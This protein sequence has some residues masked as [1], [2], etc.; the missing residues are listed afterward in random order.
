MPLKGCGPALLK[1]K[2]SAR[3]PVGPTKGSIEG[4]RPSRRSS[5]RQQFCYHGYPGDHVSVG[6]FGSHQACPFETLHGSSARGTLTFQ[7]R[8]VQNTALS[9]TYAPSPH[10]LECAGRRA[11]PSHYGGLPGIE[12]G[13]TK[14]AGDTEP[15]ARGAEC[16]AREHKLRQCPNWNQIGRAHV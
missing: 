7:L 2:S 15:V 4:S 12:H 6:S 9:V 13:Q 11:G 8:S 1:F 5:L 3:K 14:R 10:S 16:H